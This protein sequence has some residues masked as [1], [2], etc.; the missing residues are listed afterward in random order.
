MDRMP[1]A[2]HYFAESAA[3]TMAET[4][5]LK[6]SRSKSR[7]RVGTARQPNGKAMRCSA[8]APLPQRGP[9]R[10]SVALCLIGLAQLDV[11]RG[12]V[13]AAQRLLGRRALLEIG[14][15]AGLGDARCPAR[16]YPFHLRTPRVESCEVYQGASQ[17][18]VARTPLLAHPL[19]RFYRH[20]CNLS[21]LRANKTALVGRA[22]L[23]DCIA[24]A[25]GDSTS[26][27]KHASEGNLSQTWR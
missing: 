11:A 5:V 21:S 9:S 7:I 25:H 8:R 27:S 20:V 17:S 10:H 19:T 22:G 24:A 1:K 13:M 2:Q 4:L 18:G 23:D 12:N 26:T 14:V 15:R 16:E 3:L 6:F